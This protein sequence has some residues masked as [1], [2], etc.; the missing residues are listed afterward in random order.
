MKKLM[1][2]LLCLVVLA[3]SAMVFADASDEKT[4]SDEYFSAK[5]QNDGTAKITECF[6][7]K[8]KETTSIPSEIEGYTVTAIDNSAF[9]GCSKIRKLIIPKTV[10]K[11]T[12]SSLDGCFNAREFKVSKDNKTYYSKAGVLFSKK[13]KSL[14]LYPRKKTSESYSVPKNVVKIEES[15]CE[16]VS[17]LK[18]V[19]IGNDVKKIDSLAFADCFK[20]KNVKIGKKVTSI[21]NAAFTMCSKLSKVTIKG[22]VKTVGDKNGRHIFWYCNKLKNVTVKKGCRLSFAGVPMQGMGYMKYRYETS[23]KKVVPVKNK[24]AFYGTSK[25][26]ILKAKKKGTAVIKVYAVYDGSDLY[27]SKITVKVK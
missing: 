26:L 27:S 25:K 21:G 9:S 13:N 5:V 17:K 8:A 12:K 20:L 16:G 6:S 15:A 2:Y 23:N 11:L 10:N 1:L 24:K 19:T 18:F 3:T 14:M 22:K 7:K 4:V